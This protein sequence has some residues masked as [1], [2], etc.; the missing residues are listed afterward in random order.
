MIVTAVEVGQPQTSVCFQFNELSITELQFFYPHY[1]H[2]DGSKILKLGSI[3]PLFLLIL[4]FV[5][6]NCSHPLTIS[7]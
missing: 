4:E 2:S 6:T 7:L 1:G 3:E 5:S